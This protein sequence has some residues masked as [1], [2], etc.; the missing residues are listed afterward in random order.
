MGFVN[1]CWPFGQQL[2]KLNIAEILRQ[3]E[4]AVEKAEEAVEAAKKLQSGSVVSVNEIAPD[5]NGNVEIPGISINQRCAQSIDFKGLW[6]GKSTK[7]FAINMGF[8]EANAKVDLSSQLHTFPVWL[9]GAYTIHGIPFSS[10]FSYA[11]GDPISSSKDIVVINPAAG[12]IVHFYLDGDMPKSEVISG[13]G[14]G[15]GNNAAAEWEFINDI[16]LA[17]NSSTTIL[18]LDATGNSFKFKELCLLIEC[19]NQSSQTITF[20]AL[21]ATGRDLWNA[22]EAVAIALGSGSVAL[23]HSEVMGKR[24]LHQS[25]ATLGGQAK[26]QFTNPINA[27]VID[28]KYSYL[29]GYK[30]S[31]ELAAGTYIALFGK[32]K[33]T[34]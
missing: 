18:N 16:T 1:S 9:T 23:V 21:S 20:V 14:S 5:E 3:T 13:S 15:T 8:K 27:L 17:E 4:E 34:T 19:A 26:E 22:G 30:L 32:G 33:V 31:G 29:T 7:D 6:D 2:Y 12:E 25:A 11:F 24:M 10:S 28:E